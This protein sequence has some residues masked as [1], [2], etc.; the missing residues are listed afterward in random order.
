MAAIDRKHEL[1]RRLRDNGFK[2]LEVWLPRATVERIDE[3][4]DQLG[5]ESRNEVLLRLIQ[6]TLGDTRLPAD[7]SQLELLMQ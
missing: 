4:K 7:A 6:G 2:Q 1:R 3:I 5:A